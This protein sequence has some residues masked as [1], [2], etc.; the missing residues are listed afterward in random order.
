MRDGEGQQSDCGEPSSGPDTVTPAPDGDTG[1]PEYGQHDT[2][3][4]A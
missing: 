3:Q 2:A 4:G 1:D